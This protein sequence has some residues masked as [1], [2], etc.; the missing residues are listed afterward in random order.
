M[1]TIL[2]LGDR[3][4]G[5]PLQRYLIE[6]GYEVHVTSRSY[7]EDGDVLFHR[8]NAHDMVFHNSIWKMGFGV[9]VDFMVYGIPVCHNRCQ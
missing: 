5:A 3:I 2:I 7:C 6:L 1:E 8:G 4:N 9:V